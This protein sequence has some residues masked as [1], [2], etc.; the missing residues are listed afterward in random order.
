M[1]LTHRNLIAMVASAFAGRRQR[2]SP[3]VAMVTV[4]LFH[5][6]GLVYCI[7]AAALGETI[8]V[9][10][11]ERRFE[12]GRMLRAVEKFRVTHLPVA[13]PLV[14]ALVKGNMP[15]QYDLRSLE[16]VLCGGAPLGK[17]IIERFQSRFPRMHLAQ[18]R[19]CW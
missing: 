17:E 14:V 7:R 5:V 19:L 18:C 16:L 6:Y 11:G 9:P 3:V 2:P 10:T 12:L 8:V 4:P 1:V 13:P 15:E